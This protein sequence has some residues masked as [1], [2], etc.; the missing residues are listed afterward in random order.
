M[1]P[2]FIIVLI[3]FYFPAKSQDNKKLDSLCRQCSLSTLE[4]DKV[5]ALNNLANYYYKNKFIEKGDSVLS[6]QLHIAELS[7]DN[8]LILKTYFDNYITSI[9]AW[10]TKVNFE[11]V[12]QYIQQGIEFAKSINDYDH[13]AIGYSR[14]ASI[15]R[16][17][18]DYDKAVENATMGLMT[19]QNIK[20]DSIKAM[21][22]M[23]LGD[24]YHSKGQSVQACKC[25]NN[26]FDIAFKSKNY[27][28]ESDI[29]NRLENLYF[30]LGDVTEVK[31]ILLKSVGIDKKHGNGERL[32]RDYTELA[33]ATDDTFYI[34]QAL[35]LADSLHIEINKLRI[36]NILFAIYMTKLKDS[37]KALNYLNTQ[38][39]L[40][41][42]V[43][44]GGMAN[45]Y[46]TLGE[47]YQ[48]GNNPDSALFYFK[49]AEPSLFKT[50][51][52]GNA[53]YVFS[54]MAVCYKLK[55]DTKNA[56]LYYEKTLDYCKG[57]LSSIVSI[58]NSLSELYKETGN[59]EK[60]FTYKIDAT[61][62]QD[63][64]TQLSKDKDLALLDVARETRKHEVVLEQEAQDF[65][66]VRNLQ[67]M[68][69][70][71]AISIV[72]LCMLVI[73]MFT[74]SKLFIKI[75]GY[76]FF[77]SLFEFIVLLIDNSILNDATHG[78]PLKLWLIK[79]GLI[80]LLVPV[81]HFM[82]SRLIKFLGSRRLLEL[83]TKFSF[84]KWGNRMVNNS[85]SHSQIEI[86]KDT[87]VL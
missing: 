59:F 39:D 77:I 86:E 6:E 50:Y 47:I 71:I 24:C 42:F 17:R 53:K 13:I 2:L 82:E 46:F 63:S 12:S 78:Q 15:L 27:I 84:K 48:Y 79:I 69:I 67:Y 22:Y 55:K 33:R 52:A 38:S 60:A 18:G 87:A 58:S 34:K 19:F 35:S 5:D 32:I 14:L 66:N 25:Y 44:Q 7:N 28:L 4:P 76:F 56:I 68:A 74:V 23:V 85:R 64:L 26:A 1:K 11:K 21:V 57:D 16:K 41:D 30:D 65:K 36:K 73:G 10:S 54:E 83:R 49:L 72:F 9:S 70:T 81:Q 37:K 40:K 61:S 20:S 80:G 8:S 43:M 3:W 75:T 51:D 31:R 62:K 29:Y 45:Y